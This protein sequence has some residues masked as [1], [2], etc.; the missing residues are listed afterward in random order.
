MMVASSEGTLSTSTPVE[1]DE[2]P[3]AAAP[4]RTASPTRPR[5][6]FWEQ[7]G[8][9][10]V[11][12]LAVN[13]SFYLAWFARY[14]MELIRD[15]DPG[16]FVDHAQ[17][18][19]L[20]LGLAT[21]FVLLLGFRGLYH[22]PRAATALDDFSTIVTAGGVSLMV[23]FAVS[24]FVRYPAES[25]L[26][27]IFAWALI[28]IFVVLGRSIYHWAT[29]YIHSRG[30]GVAHTLVV[31]D[32]THGRMVMQ[33]IAGRPHLGYD[34]AGFLSDD[35]AVDFGRFHRLG[36][37]DDLDRV[38]D[39]HRISQVVIAL[40]STSHEQIMRI[41][42]HCRRADVEFRIVPD[43]YE[44]SLGR[45]D[46]DTVSGI[47]LLGLKASAIRGLNFFLKRVLDVVL[48]GLALL[49]SLLL[50]VPLAIAIKLDDPAGPIFYGQTRVGRWGRC[51]TAWKLRSMRADADA[52]LEQLLDQNEAEGPIFKIKDDPRRTRVG[53]FMR[54]W[55]L[56]ELPQL[57]NVFVGDMSL[58][59]PRP[60][61]PRE[62]EQYEDWQRQRLDTLPGI[63]GLWQ[64]SGRSQLGFSEQVMMDIWYIENWSLGLDLRILLRTIPAV[65]TGRGA[66]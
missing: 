31:G 57:W 37:H 52:L 22:V 50:L 29:G 16:N 20:Q 1:V 14:R 33:A 56:D 60:P 13:L 49:V 18:M 38:L 65:L 47:P 30:V 45:L 48:S 6:W 51:F 7:V 32:S 40:P 64:V 15:L 11:D 17:Y 10:A 62:V 44:M 23:L 28:V 36:G 25:R 3:P 39:H 9:V 43:L 24:T 27:L 53:R 41:V 66:F 61:T 26:T 55:S 2:V 8:L 46:I 42:E 59:G 19:P 58:V 4:E 54:R 35:S 21:V 63:T 34:V 12:A 5:S